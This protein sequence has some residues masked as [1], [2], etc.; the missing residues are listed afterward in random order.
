MDP[1]STGMVVLRIG[2]G[3]LGAAI[4][5]GTLVAAVKTFILPRGINTWLTNVTFR[6]VFLFFRF[7]VRHASYEDRDRIMAVFAPLALF[8]LPVVSLLSAMVG[9]MCLFWAID[10]RPVYEVFRLSGS[11]LLTLG[12]ASVDE[13]IFKVLEFSEAMIGLILVALL[14]AYLPTMYA[15]FS[16]REVDVA[17]LGAWAGTSFSAPEMIIRAHRTGE[18]AN[19]KAVWQSWERWFAEVE[20]SHTSLAPLAFFRSPGPERSWIT[21]AG[22]VLDCAALILSS[23]DVPYE[24]RAAFCIRGG[25]LALR[26]IA[27]FFERPYPPNPQPTDPISIT[28]SEFESVYHALQKAGVPMKPDRRQAWQDFAGWRV[29]YDAV[30]LQLAALTMAPYAQ[31]ISDRS[32]I[33][34]RNG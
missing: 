25:Y 15:A 18:L 26:Q 19:M 11:S 22:T 24:P 6:G 9:Y 34:M 16:R 3:V 29:N 33:V 13:T 21:A 28:R 4:V 2:A 1:T 17:M 5:I 8:L 14:I 12:Y 20:E 30:L 32:A 31:W 27:D 7:R 10:A 23:V